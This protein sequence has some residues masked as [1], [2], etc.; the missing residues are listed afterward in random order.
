MSRALAAGLIA[1]EP[2]AVKRHQPS[3]P[4]PIAAPSQFRLRTFDTAAVAPPPPP[5]MPDLDME[6]A[7]A[8]PAPFAALPWTATQQS[9]VLAE[10]PLK[11][12]PAKAASLKLIGTRHVFATVLDVALPSSRAAPASDATDNSATGTTRP[13]HSPQQGSFFAPRGDAGGGNDDA[14]SFWNEGQRMQ[15]D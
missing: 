14:V 5:P 1:D 4:P 13:Q 3:A 8:H 6:P 10:G 7:S 2:K 15:V 11:Q 9:P 12:P